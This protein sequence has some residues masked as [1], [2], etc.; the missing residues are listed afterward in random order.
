MLANK[1]RERKSITFQRL[2]FCD[3]WRTANSVIN[4]G[5]SPICPMF[6]SS[7]GAPY[8]PDKAEVFAK[9]FSQNSNLDGSGI[10][11]INFLS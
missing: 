1:T 6:S 3:Y 7:E 5:K 8:A 10:P 11:S 2:C 9:I 4:K